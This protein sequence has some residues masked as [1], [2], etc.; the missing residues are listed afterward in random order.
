MLV[1]TYYSD[2]AHEYALGLKQCDSFARLREF[3]LHW[4]SL[5]FDAWEIVRK[6][7]DQAWAEFQAGK[8]KENRG[9]YAGDKWAAKYGA[10]MLPEL[11]LHVSVIAEQ[12]GVPWGTAFLQCEKAGL[13]VRRGDVFVFELPEKQKA[14]VN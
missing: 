9:T 12:Y 11:L 13:I 7:D 4:A 8:Q 2:F 1:I 14:G 5:T 6:M 10:I 3:S